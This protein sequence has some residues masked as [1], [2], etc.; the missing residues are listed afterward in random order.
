M[1]DTIIVPAIGMPAT[2]AIGSDC[3]PATVIA[4]SKSGRRITLQA[5]T[6]TPTADYNYTSNQVHTFAPNPNGSLTVCSL[7]KDGRW[8]P[9]GCQANSGYRIHLGAYNS[10]SDPSF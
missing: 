9:A 2:I 10:Y 7:R 1:T 8:R 5:A 6:A 4:I 3:Y